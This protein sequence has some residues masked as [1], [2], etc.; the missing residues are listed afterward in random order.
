MDLKTTEMIRFYIGLG[1]TVNKIEYCC[2]YIRAAPF[3][4]FVANL[5]KLRVETFRSNPPLSNRCKFV[6]NST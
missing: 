6:L 2:E 1:Y 4:K 5:V 3:K